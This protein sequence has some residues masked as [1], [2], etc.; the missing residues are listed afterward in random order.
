MYAHA[1]TEAEMEEDQ[2]QRAAGQRREEQDQATEGAFGLA[3]TRHVGERALENKKVAVLQ[4][5][6]L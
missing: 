2:S 3:S 6:A 5:K 1:Q 4:K